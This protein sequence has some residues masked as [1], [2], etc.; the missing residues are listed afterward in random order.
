M[1]QSDLEK[2]VAALK[3][4]L[5]K[6]QSDFSQLAEDSKGAAKHVTEAAKDAAA[7][8]TAKLEAEAN[9]LMESLQGAKE[10]ALKTGEVAVAG[11]QDQIQE[12]PLVSAAA[13]LG[14]GFVLGMLISRRS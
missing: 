9:K 11:V 6:V 5:S 2:E 8:A 7:Q 3:K 10:S 12:R 1:N 14:L 4:E 13:A